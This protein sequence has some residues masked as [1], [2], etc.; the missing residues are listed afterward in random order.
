MGHCQVQQ[1]PRAEVRHFVPVYVHQQKHQHYAIGCHNAHLGASQVCKAD[2]QIDIQQTLLHGQQ[3][4]G[5]QSREHVLQ[6][7]VA[8]TAAT[9]DLPACMNQGQSRGCEQG[10]E[11]K[12]HDVGFEVDLLDEGIEAVHAAGREDAVAGLG[13][14]LQQGERHEVLEGVEQQ[15]QGGVV[16]HLHEAQQ[17]QD[18]QAQHEVEDVLRTQQQSR[19][20][21]DKDDQYAYR[22]GTRVAGR[23]AK[24]VGGL[25]V[26][27]QLQH[28]R[29]GVLAA[30]AVR[31]VIVGAGFAG[32]VAHL[33]GNRGH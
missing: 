8:Q 19:K 22:I 20:Y 26:R 6:G 17:A 15:S 12:R 2:G 18:L 16:G 1:L 4:K 11:E 28:G 33:C 7:L 5:P 13:L 21:C 31:V 3:Q 10:A 24:P 9:E 29:S 14:V 27:S 32:I 23:G 30:V 25:D